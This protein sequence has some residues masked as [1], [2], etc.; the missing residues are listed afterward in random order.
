M[1]QYGQFCSR[2]PHT[3]RTYLEMPFHKTQRS[4]NALMKTYR[5]LQGLYVAN[6]AV[7]F[8]PIRKLF[9]PMSNVRSVNKLTVVNATLEF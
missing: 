7:T 9:I 8:T 3:S 6:H 1:S 4:T 5:S 2:D